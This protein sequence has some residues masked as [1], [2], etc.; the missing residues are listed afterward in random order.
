M[1][2]KNNLLIDLI[3]STIVEMLPTIVGLYKKIY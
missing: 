2:V 1:G 3:K